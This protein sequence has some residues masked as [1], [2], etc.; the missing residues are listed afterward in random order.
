M[1]DLPIIPPT[2]AQD[3]YPASAQALVNEAVGNARVQLDNSGF[4]VVLA[5]STTPSATQRSYLWFNT[6]YDRTYRWDAA[7]GAWVA[8]HPYAFG[9]DV[10]V[11]WTGSLANIDTFDGGSA[12]TV[13]DAAGPMWQRDT[14]M[15]GRTAIGVGTLPS[16]ATLAE[17]D[18]GG[19]DKHTQL[20]TEI[21]PHTHTMT[22]VDNTTNTLAAGS[23]TGGGI[24]IPREINAQ[25]GS[26][27][28]T[29][30]SAVPFNV[31]NPYKAG[32]WLKRTARIYYRA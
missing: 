4:S 2:L 28:G 13:G 27:G 7:V 30:G 20:L 5:Q 29:S 26:A 25:T 17:G 24:V 21:V 11:F 14:S 23:G 10:R 6:T 32:Y 15:D 19:E 8:R 16:G 12:G 22:N 3:C 1:V 9:T 18:T 31:L